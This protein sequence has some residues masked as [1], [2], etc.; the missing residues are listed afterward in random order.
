[1]HH[2]RFPAS[3]LSRAALLV[4]AML[5]LAGGLTACN[6]VRGAGQDVSS[7]GHDVSRGANASQ[8]AITKSTG[9][10]PR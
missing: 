10:S 1:M 6:T 5:G 3:S 9:A 7:V 8:N 2:D 4:V